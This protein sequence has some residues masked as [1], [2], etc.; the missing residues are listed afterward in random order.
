MKYELH[1]LVFIA[2]SNESVLFILFIKHIIEDGQRTL[3]IRWM[4][5]K[6][7]CL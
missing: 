2:P 6:N 7:V 5:E 3:S 4:A 1:H